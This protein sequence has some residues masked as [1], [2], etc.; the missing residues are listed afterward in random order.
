MPF[1]TI[2]VSYSRITV[3]TVEVLCPETSFFKLH[4]ITKHEALN[5]GHHA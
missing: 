2:G 4:E 1:A 5:K 3:G